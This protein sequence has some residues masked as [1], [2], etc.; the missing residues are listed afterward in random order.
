MIRTVGRRGNRDG[1]GAEVRLVSG[2]LT[3]VRVVRSGSS[4]LSASDP[5]LHFGLGNR[6]GIDSLEVRWPGGERQLF[7]GL[8]VNR[9]LVLEQN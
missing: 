8:Q 1:V 7:H 4:Y 3:Q 5:R 6:T 2:D 9:L